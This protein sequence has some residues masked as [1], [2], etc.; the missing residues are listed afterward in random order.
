MADKPP[1]KSGRFDTGLIRELAAILREADLGEIEI[2]QGGMR[3]K[4]VK[5]EAKAVHV[6]QAYAPAPATQTAAPAAVA[7]PP[8]APASL[9]DHPGAVKSPMVGTVYLQAEEG[10]AKYVKV[11]DTVNAGATLLLIEAMKTFNPVTAPR[12]GKVV[13]IL[14]DNQQ[15]VEFGE[16][17]VI[18][19]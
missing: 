6:A 8:P 12:A 13:Q 3:I 4:V 16:P 19:E 9:R 2:E 14:V 5:P 17:L 10:S 11:G 7:A 18:I 15:P 1:E